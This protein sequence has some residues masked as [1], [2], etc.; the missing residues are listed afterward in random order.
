MTLKGVPRQGMAW[1]SIASI[2]NPIM[3]RS[4]I[5]VQAT[6]S[7]L[8]R[9]MF[10]SQ[11]DFAITDMSYNFRI[12]LGFTVDCLPLI[13]TTYSYWVNRNSPAAPYVPV[14]WFEWTHKG[15]I[16][17]EGQD[18]WTWRVED[19]NSSERNIC[20]MPLV[21]GAGGVGDDIPNGYKIQYDI[22]DW[23]QPAAERNW[24][25]INP[26]NGTIILNQG[27]PPVP[28]R[29]CTVR[30]CLYLGNDA[31]PFLEREVDFHVIK[32]RTD[33]Q[34]EAMLNC[35]P[36]LLYGEQTR[37]SL[38][39]C[40]VYID[41][42]N[43]NTEYGFCP[44]IG[45]HGKSWYIK[46]TN[47]IHFAGH[48]ISVNEVEDDGWSC[49]IEAGNVT[50]AAEIA[51]RRTGQSVVLFM[52]QVANDQVEMNRMKAEAPA[53]GNGLSTPQLYLM[54]NIGTDM[55]QNT[56]KKPRELENTRAAAIINNSF[57]AGYP[58]TTG[59]EPASRVST[60]DLSNLSFRL[61]DCNFMPIRLLNPMYITLQVNPVDQNSNTDITPF[62]GKLP[63][64]KP[65]LRELQKMQEQQQQQQ[66]QQMQLAEQEK[67]K[68]DGVMS[69]LSPAQQLQLLALPPDKQE[70]FRMY[71]ERVAVQQRQSAQ[72]DQQLLQQ[73]A[74][75][76]PERMNT[77]EKLIYQF[78]PDRE[79]AKLLARQAAGELGNFKIS[80][81]LHERARQQAQEDEEVHE[82]MATEQQQLD[83]AQ[84]G[85]DAVNAEN[86]ADEVRKREMT[87]ELGDAPEENS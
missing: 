63:K 42:D 67:Q 62:L 73:L 38:Q 52:V 82:E 31:S 20:A 11:R 35:K 59:G 71:N 83:A 22:K 75:T 64:D 33:G 72:Q 66:L 56:F 53:V 46:N 69:K 24:C 43:K 5:D 34:G 55:F 32:R 18:Y 74:L 21:I 76:A 54:S 7:D 9:I 44:D 12:L 1:E 45:I 58:I 87:T 50:G 80:Q 61:V 84:A 3:H 6:I 30:C 13:A 41:K 86:N 39:S 29:I 23:K 36:V 28:Q 60:M 8:H 37:V 85:V 48:D 10:L 2:L 49:V 17:H 65:T 16:P 79:K 77:I 14:M 51:F 40:E 26:D 19:A 57:S 68:L 4:G 78:L 81:A 47:I 25:V 15:L 27:L 70:Y